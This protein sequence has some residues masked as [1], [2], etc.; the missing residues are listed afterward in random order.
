M[1][2]DV[3]LVGESFSTFLAVSEKETRERKLLTVRTREPELDEER[4][5]ILLTRNFYSPNIKGGVRNRQG[6]F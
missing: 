2:K 1:N 4:K 5:I 3:Y 6:V